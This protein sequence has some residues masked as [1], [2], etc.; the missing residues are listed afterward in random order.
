MLAGE[1]HMQLIGIATAL[2]HIKSGRMRGL[3]VSGGKRSAVVPEVP[4]VAE[5]P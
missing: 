3:A 4:T 2:P 5:A 1:I